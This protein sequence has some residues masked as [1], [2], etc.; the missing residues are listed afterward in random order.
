M[1]FQ[2][3]HHLEIVTSTLKPLY[4]TSSP[5]HSCPLPPTIDRSCSDK[6]CTSASGASDTHSRSTE[7]FPRTSSSELGFFR[8][9]RLKK[10]EWLRGRVWS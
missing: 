8:V 7:R 5:H 2:I 4:I 1:G 3:N 6:V 10:E 9:E